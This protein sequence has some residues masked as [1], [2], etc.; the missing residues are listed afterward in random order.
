MKL[1]ASRRLLAAE[2]IE[3]QDIEDITFRNVASLVASDPANDTYKRMEQEM[4]KVRVAF[5]SRICWGALS[6]DSKSFIVGAA[7]TK[8]HVKEAVAKTWEAFVL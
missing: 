7:P 2:G 5:P 4:K 6:P 8:A 1:N 3:G